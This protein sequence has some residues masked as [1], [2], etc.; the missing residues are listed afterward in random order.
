DYQSST[1]TLTFARGE[2]RKTVSVPVI[3]DRLVEANEN[4]LVRL[5]S[6][7]RGQFSD[8]LGVVTIQDDEPR[9][10]IS[11]VS[12]LEGCGCFGTTPFTFTVSMSAAYDQAVTVTYAT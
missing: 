6:T 5:T 7:T 4:F 1:G 3:G 8:G 12:A 9:I 11:D 10:R 2:T